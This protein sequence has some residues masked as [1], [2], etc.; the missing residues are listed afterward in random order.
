MC[1]DPRPYLQAI[2]KFVLVSYYSCPLLTTLLSSRS[3]KMPESS[4]R[5][6]LLL[7]AKTGCYVVPAQFNN[8]DLHLFELQRLR[9]VR[10]SPFTRLSMYAFYR[11]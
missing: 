3:I 4:D 6:Y 9:Y 2:P 8:N 5:N 7:G 11:S 10:S 1:R